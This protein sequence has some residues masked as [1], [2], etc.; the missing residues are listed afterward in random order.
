MR[1][2]TVCFYSMLKFNYSFKE[3]EVERQTSN[4]GNNVV[5]TMSSNISVE[6]DMDMEELQKKLQE[7]EAEVSKLREELTGHENKV[8]DWNAENIHSSRRKSNSQSKSSFCCE[9]AFS[10]P[11]EAE[12]PSSHHKNFISTGLYLVSSQHPLQI[13]ERTR[14]SRKGYN[15]M[16]K[17]LDR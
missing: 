8:Y 12:V 11:T 1:K 9:D 6:S 5:K 4:V 16:T 14:K 15:C 7:S 13:Y 17:K 10:E 3:L 2:I